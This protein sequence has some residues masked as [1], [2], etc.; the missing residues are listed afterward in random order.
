[1]RKESFIG[2]GMGA[3]WGGILSIELQAYRMHFYL[4]MVSAKDRDFP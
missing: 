2:A 1:M 3:I 4:N